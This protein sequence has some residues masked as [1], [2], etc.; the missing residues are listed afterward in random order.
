MSPIEGGSESEK[1]TRKKRDALTVLPL[2]LPLARGAASRGFAS[3]PCRSGGPLHSL[4][5]LLL[6]ALHYKGY[7]FR[8]IV[9]GRGAGRWRNGKGERA[10]AGG[11]GMGVDVGLPFRAEGVLLM[12]VS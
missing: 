8:W 11:V 9:G 10:R 3:A 1:T 2:T 6:L 12:C 4:P 7:V 5:S